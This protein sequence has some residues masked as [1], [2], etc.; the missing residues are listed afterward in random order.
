MGWS[1]ITTWEKMSP[2]IYDSRKVGRRKFSS[3]LWK[4]FEYLYEEINKIQST[5]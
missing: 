2:E 5:T 3:T 1:V 4:D